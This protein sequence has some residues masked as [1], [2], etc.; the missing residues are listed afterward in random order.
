MGNV[1]ESAG[2]RGA[3]TLCLALLAAA[4]P[5]AGRAQTP[6]AGHAEPIARVPTA[7]FPNSIVSEDRAFAMTLATSPSPIRLNEPFELTVLIRPLT[8]DTRGALS[9]TVDAQM[10]AHLHGMNTR[11]QR[12]PLGEDKFLFRGLL[13]HMAGEWELVIDAAQGRSRDRGVVRLVIE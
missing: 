11:P 10:P 5:G 8:P 7:M 4:L 2:H 13:F 3:L 9:A 12:E 6:H 1:R